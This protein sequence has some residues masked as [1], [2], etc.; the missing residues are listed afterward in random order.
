MRLYR[1]WKTQ[2]A[3]QQRTFV[4]R[5][6]V[7]TLCLAAV[8]TG[9]LVMSHVS[10]DRLEAWEL[11]DQ[12]QRLLA[13]QRSGTPIRADEAV[14]PLLSHD[15]LRSVEYSLE[16]DPG[17]ALSRY[18]ALERDRAALHGL[19]NFDALH[20]QT[21][22]NMMRQTECLSNAIYYEARSEKTAG[23]LAVAE[24]I[25][26]RV[27]DH[28]YPNSICEVVF[29]GATRTTGCQ[30]TFTCDGAMDKEPKGW[31]WDKAQTIA[32]H[33]AM[34]L[35]EKK[36]AGATHYHATYVNPVWN[37]GL[38]RTTKI[39]QHIFYRFPR[40]NEWAAASAKQERRLA[41]RRT[42]LKVVKRVKAKTVA[43]NVTPKPKVDA[44]AA[45]RSFVASQGLTPQAVTPQISTP[46]K[47]IAPTERVTRRVITT[48]TQP[49]PTK[50]QTVRRTVTRTY[51]RPAE[52]AS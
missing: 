20:M 43:A 49:A 52:P 5:A 39:G 22:E 44:A 19:K 9:L 4:A 17:S 10:S 3:T 47:T 18:A 29:Q 8:M 30:F 45:T 13:A 7:S 23:Q 38:V 40:G 37:S 24:V 33:V 25:M 21:A 42:G 34:N 27:K 31:R 51:K 1:W 28:R 11:R 14:S 6:C 50:S 2:T 46:M 41:Q 12:G 48:P 36:T 16:R 32:A 26:N 15:W 35:N